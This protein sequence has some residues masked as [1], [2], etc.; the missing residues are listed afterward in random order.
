MLKIVTFKYINHKAIGSISSP[1]NTKLEKCTNLHNGNDA[2]EVVGCN[3]SRMPTL[4]A[5]LLLTVQLPDAPPYD[6][7]PP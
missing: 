7:M 2:A 4:M 6:F 1:V 5:P 3:T